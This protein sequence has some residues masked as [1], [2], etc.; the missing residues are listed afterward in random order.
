MVSVQLVH[1]FTGERHRERKVTA[2]T[3]FEP[4]LLED[5]EAAVIRPRMKEENERRLRDRDQGAYVS[6]KYMVCL[7][8]KLAGGYTDL[9]KHLKEE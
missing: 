4:L 2:N 3:Q 5:S 7:R 8:C 9:R 6:E 1:C